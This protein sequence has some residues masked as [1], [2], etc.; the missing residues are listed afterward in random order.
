MKAGIF[1]AGK[2]AGTFLLAFILAGCRHPAASQPAPDAAL[3]RMDAESAGGRRR[4]SGRR[5]KKS[6]QGSRRGRGGGATLDGQVTEDALDEE[7][8]CGI[9]RGRSCDIQVAVKRG[10]FETGLEPAFPE[11]LDC[12]GIDEAWAIDYTYKRDREQYHG[13]IDMPTSYGTPIIA[14]AAG[15][16][17]G[18]YEGRRTMRGREI[19]LRHSPEDTGLPVWTYT[20][21]AHFDEMPKREVGERVRMGEVLGP[22]GNSGR[23][24]RRERRPAIHFAVWFSADSRYVPRRR[25]IIPVKGFWMDPIALYRGGPPFDSNSMKALPE[26]EKRVPVSVMTKDGKVTPP[27]AKVVWPY[28]C[29]RK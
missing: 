6:Q 12:P 4:N 25:K 7:T 19:I 8:L 2:I 29:E 5:R 1:S 14:A 18:K 28:Y 9:G 10:L 11:N 27:G 13:G 3:K 22:T 17:V 23:Q 21:Y 24:G 15:T 26:G 16:V 20:Q